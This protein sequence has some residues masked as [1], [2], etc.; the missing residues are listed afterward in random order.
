VVLRRTLTLEIR[1][2]GLFP[3]A[4]VN[5]GFAWTLTFED[6]NQWK[7]HEALAYK[8]PWE[9]YRPEELPGWRKAA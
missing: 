8:T 2:K 7:P 1:L 3:L 9:C 6:Y 5:G 4:S